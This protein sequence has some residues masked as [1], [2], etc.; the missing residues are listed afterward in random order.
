MITSKLS[1]LS[2]APKS[3]VENG[4]KF[5]FTSQGYFGIFEG[6]WVNLLNKVDHTASQ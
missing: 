5:I 4:P 3:P 6:M 2:K 1:I